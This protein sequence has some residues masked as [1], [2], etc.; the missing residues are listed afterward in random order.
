VSFSATLDASKEDGWFDAV[1]EL[2]GHLQDR[3]VWTA[4]FGS[5]APLDDLLLFPMA[6]SR[7]NADSDG[8][9]LKGVG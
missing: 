7:L 1:R 4:E 5:N 9:S 8:D 3:R 2:I 6:N